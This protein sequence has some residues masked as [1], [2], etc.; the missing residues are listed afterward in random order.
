MATRRIHA[1]YF[2]TE[3]YTAESYTDEGLAWI[4]AAS[5]KNVLLRHHPERADTGLSNVTNACHPWE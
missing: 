2:Y 4:E 1:D 5:M 3:G